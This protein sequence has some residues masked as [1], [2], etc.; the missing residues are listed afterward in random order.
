MGWSVGFVNGRDVGYAV[1]AICDFPKCKVNIDRGLSYVCGGLGGEAEFGCGL[2]FC[3][4]HL[5]T[6]E[7][8]NN[9]QEISPQLCER[10]GHNFEVGDENWK[11]FW[12]A[13]EPKQD[14]PEWMR[15]KLTDPS[16]QQWRDEN[17]NEVRNIKVLL[18]SRRTP[19]MWA[20]AIASYIATGCGYAAGIR[21]F[22]ELPNEDQGR[23]WMLVVI[24]ISFMM[25]GYNLMRLYEHM[26]EEA[27]NAN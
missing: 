9:S 12:R 4:K 5:R 11:Q 25:V 16:W 19:K 26:R 18:G 6:Y 24:A 1:P 3:S 23:F 7:R 13:F 21:S 17:P 2:Y 22:F 8:N 14:V 15:H 27:R 20:T 10:C